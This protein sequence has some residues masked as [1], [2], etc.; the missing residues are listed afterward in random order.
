MFKIVTLLKLEC[1]KT[2]RDKS[3]VIAHVTHGASMYIDILW[4]Y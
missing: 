3:C 4:N 2:E 1:C